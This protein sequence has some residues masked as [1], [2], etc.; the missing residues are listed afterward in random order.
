VK[1]NLVRD[2]V[3]MAEALSPENGS[4]GLTVYII[5]AGTEF[6][7]P[8]ADLISDRD[9]YIVTTT[10]ADGEE[11]FGS[12]VNESLNEALNK[13]HENMRKDCLDTAEDLLRISGTKST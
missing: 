9:R 2:C 10:D 8:H 12:V 3:F 7:H 13:L 1:E 6:S 4:Q 5:R 11:T